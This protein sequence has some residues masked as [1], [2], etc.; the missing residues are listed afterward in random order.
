MNAIVSPVGI[1][2]IVARNIIPIVGI[3][4]F[5]WSASNVLILYFLDT[6][7][8]M[9]VIIA[10]LARSFAPGREDGIGA[11]LNAQAGYVLAALLVVGIFAVPLGMPVGIALAI[12]GFSFREALADRSL[13]IG[14]LVQSAMALWSYV[15]LYRALDTHTPEALKLKQR[16][17]LVLMRWVAVLMVCYF[18]LDILPTSIVV[19]VLVVAYVGA[20]IFAEIAPDRFLR[21]TP[22][23]FAET[24]SADPPTAWRNKRRR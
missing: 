23:D 3:V 10:G 16:F 24:I 9:A 1:A 11:L 8:S 7:L 18:A 15:S 20:S 17:G 5:H 19:Y 12:S 22:G 2:Q 13:R 6:L 4:L 14:M 21:G